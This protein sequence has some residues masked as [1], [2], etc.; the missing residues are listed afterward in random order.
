DSRSWRAAMMSLSG[1]PERILVNLDSHPDRTLGARAMD[2]TVLAQEKTAA[3]FRSRPTTFKAQGTETGADWETIPGLGTVRWAPPEISFTNQM[4]LHWGETPVI[5]EHHP[6]PASGAMWVIIPSEKTVFIGDLVPK[7]QPPFLAHSDLPAWLEALDI[8]MS[9]E[10]R[11]FT[12]ISGRGGTVSSSAI[13]AQA[14]FIKQIHDR[15]E[16]M[17]SRSQHPEATEKLIETFLTHFKSSATRHKQY[18]Q[19]MRYGLRH[20]Y[21]R[22]YHMGSAAEE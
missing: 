4:A 15:L 16:K 21:A 14:E 12:F 2:C 20:Y 9:A 18:V 22:H 7:N 5:L 3:V 17:A 6:G 13:K 19:R 8:L 10:Y 1:G 11:G